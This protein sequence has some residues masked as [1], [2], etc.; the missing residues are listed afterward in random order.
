MWRRDVQSVSLFL[1]NFTSN[2]VVM[3]VRALAFRCLS[4]YAPVSAI[5]DDYLCTCQPVKPEHSLAYVQLARK[6]TMSFVMSS[7][8]AIRTT[9]LDGKSRKL[10]ARAF[11]PAELLARMSLGR[12]GAARDAE[13]VL[14]LIG[15]HQ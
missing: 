12:Y 14:L 1:T 6:A 5:V 13:S 7:L 10:A 15:P 11:A 2:V 3:A 9:E 4:C 8:A